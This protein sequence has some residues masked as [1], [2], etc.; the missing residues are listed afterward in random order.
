MLRETEARLRAS[1]STAPST[2]GGPRIRELL[3]ARDEAQ[4]A[5]AH[6]KGR[7]YCAAGDRGSA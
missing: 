6:A 1:C 5:R 7:A 4:L 2:S 3:L